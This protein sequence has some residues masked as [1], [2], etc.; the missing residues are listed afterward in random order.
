MGVPAPTY[1]YSLDGSGLLGTG[2]SSS[3]LVISDI[4]AVTTFQ[5]VASNSAGNALS[6]ASSGTPNV[7]GSNP[8]ITAITPGTNQLSVNFTQT[9]MGVPTPTYYYSLDGTT[10]LGSG[11]SSS[12]LVISDISAVTTFQI[13]ASNSAGN[14]LSDASSGTPDYLGS[15]PVINTIT[16]GTNQLTIGFTQ[17]DTGSPEPSYYYSLDGTTL[18][19]SGVSSSPLVISDI[20]AT[21]TFQIVASSPLGNVFSD[22]SSGTPNVV[23]SNP[24]ITAITPG[25]NLLTID[26]TQTDMG[27][28]A[29]TYYYS[30]DGSGLLGTGVSSSPLVISDISA[31]T[32]FQ[33][34]ASNSAGNAFSDASSGTPNVV[35]SNPVITAITP[36]TNLLTVDFTQ[37]DMGVPA[38]TYY[39]SLN[40]TTLLG[41]GVSSSP[42]VISDISAVTTFQ[43]VASNS[44]GNAFSD[45]SSS[46]PDYLGSIPVILMVTN[47]ENQLTVDF[48][49]NDLGSPAPTYYYSLDGST[50]LGSGVSSSPLVITDI[51]DTTPFYII[52]SNP[53]GDIPSS[54]SSGVQTFLGSV[55]VITTI[56]PGTNQLT[57]DFTQTRLGKPDPT[58]YFSFDGSAVLGPGV[59]SS[60][61]VITDISAITTFY[62]VASNTEGNVFSDASSGTPNYLGIAPV[63]NTVTPGTNQL[64]V[65]FTHSD[66]GS[67]APTYYYSFDG[68]TLLGA[69][70]SSSPLVITDISATTTFYVVASNIVGN[71]SSAGSFGTPNVV[72][73]A[74]VINTITPGTNQLTVD[75]S[76]SDSG[77]PAPTYYYSLNGTTLLGAG[78]SSSPLVITDISAVTTFQIVAS[79]SAGNALSDASSGIPDYL[80]TTPIIN[81]VTSGTNQLTVGFSQS[82][83]GSPAPT[84]YYSFDGTT[85][86]GAGVSSSPLVITDI[87]ATTTFYVVASNIV[88]DVP[89]DSSSGTPNFLGTAPIINSITP[90]TNQLTVGFSQ[91]ATGSPAPTYYYSFDGS[92]LLGSGVS[93][94]PLVITDISSAQN[95]QIVASNAA[96]NVFSDASSAIPEYVG[97]VPTITNIVPGYHQISVE[98]TQSNVS[99]PPPSYYY[100]LN[101]VSLV[102]SGVSSSPLVIPTINVPTQFYVVASNTIGNVFS[103]QTTGTPLLVR[104]NEIVSSSL[105]VA[106]QIRDFSS[107]WLNQH[108]Y[109]CSQIMYLQG[110]SNSSSPT[111][112]E[113]VTA[114]V[115]YAGT[116]AIE[117]YTNDVSGSGFKSFEVSFEDRTNTRFPTNTLYICNANINENGTISVGFYYYLVSTGLWTFAGSLITD[118]ISTSYTDWSVIEI[119]RGRTAISSGNRMYSQLAIN[120]VEL[121]PIVG[122]WLAF[123]KSYILTTS[124]VGTGS[125]SSPYY[126]FNYAADSGNLPL[127]VYMNGNLTSGIATLSDSKSILLN[128][129]DNYTNNY[130]F[131][132]LTLVEYFISAP[133]NNPPKIP[134]FGENARI[135]CF[136]KDLFEEEYVSI[137]NIRRG[138][139][140][141]TLKH[142]YV[143]VEM[144]GKTVMR[145]NYAEG[146]RHKN[147]L[148]KC[149]KRN[150]PEMTN[151]D[152]ILTGCHS[153]L[154]DGFKNEDERRKTVEVNRKIYITDDKYRLPA[155]VDERAEIYEK[156]GTFT[157]YHLALQNDDYYMNYG[158]YANGLLV[159]TSSRRYMRELSNMELL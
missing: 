73:T 56:T 119:G 44:A 125:L 23:G 40:G 104:L 61:L 140:V 6:D 95:V 116:L 100:S 60:P 155:C 3:P 153:I 109:N 37:T 83:T 99:N 94:S 96:G 8:V 25:T 67:P 68:T 34:V 59:S 4:S 120:N 132:Y 143:A 28:P 156:S 33:I 5:I 151:E 79:N 54:V 2:V 14:A 1:Y 141:K 127:R 88:G 13:V 117:S 64:T 142:G 11:V 30:L 150:Y 70:V 75:F 15:A 27:V 18:L 80:G 72:G 159:E 43:I 36:G 46:T 74:P 50:L 26:F 137:K 17:S 110:P 105:N 97:S 24:V 90:G 101:G 92:T 9:D 49:Q 16:P 154:V 115:N 38:P 42:L 122:P 128:P 53:L 146:E 87:S 103:T 20:S 76:Q 126:T 98:F 93:S 133:N 148:Y 35:G 134:C 131:N 39:Y 118:A 112:Y 41:T 106:F 21:T 31:T 52:A 82:D 77:S 57:V 113:Y 58:Y 86:L 51:S 10:L 91:S 157:I 47:G 55:P 81:T 129:G 147:R 84:Y 144:I 114:Y 102:G 48:I 123:Y 138:M 69:G 152:L 63:I 121:F 89:S 149:T 108:S 65:N 62:V 130:A 19:G 45:A 111:G 22:A 107:T 85:L 124:T 12:P 145:N 158:I 136:N 78:V 32:T 66:M 71:V 29:P 135:L 139:L 7:V